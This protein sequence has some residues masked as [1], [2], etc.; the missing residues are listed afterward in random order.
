MHNQIITISRQC[1]SGGHTIG[2]LLSERLGIPFYDKKIL[3]IVSQRSGLAEETIEREGEYGS[4]NPLFSMA[5][6][7]ASRYDAAD[8]G[9]MIL[10]DQINAFQ[11]EL[12]REL[13]EQ[14]SCI[15][16]GRCADYILSDH[17]D[18]FHVFIHGNLEERKKRI[19]EEHGI[20]P[21]Q[22]EIH[23]K[24]RDKKRAKHYGHFTDQVWGKAENYHL[25]LDSSR[26]GIEK[27]VNI[28]VE[29]LNFSK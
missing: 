3:E 26:L 12:I 1:G 21:E 18:A 23:V 8:K 10:S 17:K 22:A 25:C 28:I 4:F 24:M 2:Q 9:N 16:V 11:T 7:M 14:G 15:I 13:A 6:S 20:E 19:I 29:C 27:C 5:I